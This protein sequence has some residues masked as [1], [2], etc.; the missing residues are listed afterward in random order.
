MQTHVFC[1]FYS[2][3]TDI[4]GK[5]NL[6]NGI[7]FTPHF[8]NDRR[9]DRTKL[10][11]ILERGAGSGERGAGRWECR[12]RLVRA[13]GIAI[14]IQHRKHLP[15]SRVIINIPHCRD[16]SCYIKDYRRWRSLP[17]RESGESVV[18]GGRSPHQSGRDSRLGAGV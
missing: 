17:E 6:S 11:V 2:P 4:C 15:D 8:A 14:P 16:L 3:F 1:V 9:S 7:A 5:I 18:D 10:K 12:S 13:A